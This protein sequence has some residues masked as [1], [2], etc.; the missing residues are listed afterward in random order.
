L[1][2]SLPSRSPLCRRQRGKGAITVRGARISVAIPTRH[3]IVQHTGEALNRQRIPHEMAPSAR[4]ILA[5]VVVRARCR[6]AGHIVLVDGNVLPHREGRCRPNTRR[7]GGRGG[8]PPTRPVTLSL[9]AGAASTLR[10]PPQLEGVARASSQP[11]ARSG[12]PLGTLRSLSV[13]LPG[14]VEV[15]SDPRIRDLD[16]DHRCKG[17]CTNLAYCTLWHATVISMKFPHVAFNRASLLLTR[18]HQEYFGK[19][20][21]RL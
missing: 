5:D 16:R 9:Q 17:N 7:P 2:K 21:T 14:R 3:Q 4:H 1:R 11:H 13:G 19:G 8:P 6:L 20:I 12:S 10:K 15:L 18:L